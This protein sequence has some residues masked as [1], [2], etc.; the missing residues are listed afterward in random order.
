MLALLFMWDNISK[1]YAGNENTENQR[2][3]STSEATKWFETVEIIKT[4]KMVHPWL[5][6]NKNIV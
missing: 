3:L 2:V 4:L 6:L 1:S 5:P